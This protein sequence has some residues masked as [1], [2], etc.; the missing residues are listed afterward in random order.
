MPSFYIMLRYHY[1]PWS[2]VI[3]WL[4]W[5]LWYRALQ[6]LRKCNESWSDSRLSFTKSIMHAEPRIETTIVTH[7]HSAM[8]TNTIHSPREG[9]P[10]HF[11]NLSICLVVSTEVAQSPLGRKCLNYIKYIYIYIYCILGVVQ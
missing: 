6:K 8:T 9:I 4:I 10:M 5:C 2:T 1:L 3:R 11:I 7:H